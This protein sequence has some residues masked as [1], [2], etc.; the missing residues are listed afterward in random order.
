MNSI[1][2]KD[3]AKLVLK[4][5]IHFGVDDSR[6]NRR[7]LFDRDLHGAE[8]A[9]AQSFRAFNGES[10]IT[11]EQIYQRGR[12]IACENKGPLYKSWCAIKEIMENDWLYESQPFEPAENIS[13]TLIFSEFVALNE[14]LHHVPK[15]VSANVYKAIAGSIRNKDNVSA[16]DIQCMISAAKDYYPGELTTADTLHNI[17]EIHFADPSCQPD[18]IDVDVE[19]EVN[20]PQGETVVECKQMKDNIVETVEEKPKKAEKINFRGGRSNK[21]DIREELKRVYG[22]DVKLV[23]DYKG[24]HFDITLRCEHC[25]K[26]WTRR[27]EY[28]LFHAYKCPHCAAREAFLNPAMDVSLYNRSADFKAE[29]LR[30]YIDHFTDGEY[31]YSDDDIMKTSS[32][33]I[34]FTHKT[35]GTTFYSTPKRMKNMLSKGIIPCPKCRRESVYNTTDNIEEEVSMAETTGTTDTMGLFELQKYYVQAYRSTVG[36]QLTTGWKSMTNS[37]R[38]VL[39]EQYSL[40][41]VSDNGKH[42]NLPVSLDDIEWIT[43]YYADLAKTPTTDKIVLDRAIRNSK[44]WAEILKLVT[45][46]FTKDEQKVSV[47]EGSAAK[48]SEDNEDGNHIITVEEQREAKRI[49]KLAALQQ[50]ELRKN[51]EKAL[52]DTDN[53]NFANAVEAIVKM[54]QVA[55]S[56]H[57]LPDEVVAYIANSIG[58]KLGEISSDELDN[59]KAD[60]AK[61]RENEKGLREKVKELMDE[62]DKAKAWKESV[63]GLLASA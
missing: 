29:T 36:T 47:H 26:E 12:E 62:L 5:Y 10:V 25:G 31:M 1:K 33:A 22:D 24:T 42:I 37:M 19:T 58:A 40:E 41:K 27:A 18:T 9:V 34:K 11:M 15:N 53:T 20:E 50:K 52:K 61:S 8:R 32:G 4:A 59:L 51:L 35:C 49:Q 46:R 54:I 60:L 16:A 55:K 6:V 39:P 13:G 14:M 48:A 17:Y 23:S 28:A 57:A 63:R 21:L 45:P 44:V 43:Y 30:L 2:V 7:W 56:M 38:D 3:L